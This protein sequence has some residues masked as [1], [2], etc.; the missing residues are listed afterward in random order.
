MTKHNLYTS[1][2]NFPA[3]G[4]KE[5]EEGGAFSNSDKDILCGIAMTLAHSQPKQQ[6]FSMSLWLIIQY[7]FLPFLFPH[8]LQFCSNSHSSNVIW[9]RHPLNSQHPAPPRGSSESFSMSSDIVKYLLGGNYP[10][11][12][13][14]YQPEHHREVK[15][16]HLWL[17]FLCFF[18]IKNDKLP[19]L[20]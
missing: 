6:I 16:S 14:N 10:P 17:L 8:K 12:V 13:E 5:S 7:P 15:L 20:C 11:M 2:Y 3:D 4:S 19:Y 18:V 1:Y 9:G